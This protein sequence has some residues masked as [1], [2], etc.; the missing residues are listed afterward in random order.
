MF[1]LIVR[2]SKSERDREIE[3]LMRQEHQ[4][5]AASYI[6]QLGIEPATWSCAQ[7][8]NRTNL[9]LSQSSTLEPDQMGWNFFIY[10][11]LSY[12]YLLLLLSFLDFILL[13]CN[14]IFNKHLELGSC[15]FP[16]STSL[17]VFLIL[18]NVASH[19]FS[20]QTLEI[21]SFISQIQL[22]SKS[23]SVYLQNLSRNQP[24]FLWDFS[25]LY[26]YPISLQFIINIAVV[27]SCSNVSRS[28]H[29]CA[30]SP[31][32]LLWLPISLSKNLGL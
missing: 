1:L 20:G 12:F 14:W 4:R 3:A 32:V 2:G 18:Y 29:F 7:A 27:W 16:K 10:W 21:I 19:Y 11:W 13:S 5:L 26:F 25:N 6:P 17:E 8:R 24:S 28:C 30:L 9:F 23:Y 22:V 31:L 15:S